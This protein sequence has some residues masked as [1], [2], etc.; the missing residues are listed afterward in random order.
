MHRSTIDRASE[1]K[2]AG[3]RFSIQARR[4]G[5][6]N[7]KTEAFVEVCKKEVESDY[8]EPNH[9]RSRI[10]SPRARLLPRIQKRS[11]ANRSPEPTLPPANHPRRSLAPVSVPRAVATG[12]SRYVS[13]PSTEPTTSFQAGISLQ[14]QALFAANYLKPRLSVCGVTFV[15]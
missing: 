8:L 2:G 9:H 4:T 14:I 6:A 10:I 7:A 12:S 3:H 15:S 13:D 5:G 11:H 1:A